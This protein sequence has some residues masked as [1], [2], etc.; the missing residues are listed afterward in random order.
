MYIRQSLSLRDRLCLIFLYIVFCI[1]NG[2]PSFRTSDL[3]K[4]TDPFFVLLYVFYDKRRIGH[5][6]RISDLLLNLFL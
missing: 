2:L 5:I 3:N 6:C 4:R 1:K